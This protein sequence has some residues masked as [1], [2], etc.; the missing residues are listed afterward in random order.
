ME[1]RQM[2]VK[3]AKRIIRE[4][5]DGN[6]WKRMEAVAIAETELD[7]DISTADIYKWAESEDDDEQDH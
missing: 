4:D 1:R 2:T 6:I 3:E 7:P 5:P